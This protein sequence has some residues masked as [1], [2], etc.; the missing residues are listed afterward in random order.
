M[1]STGRGWVKNGDRW[2]VATVP[3]DGSLTVRRY[4]GGGTVRLPA[5][6]VAEHVELGYTTTAARAQGMTVDTAHVV[7]G[8]PT[9]SR[10]T[11]YA[12]MTRGRH[13]NHIYVATDYVNDPDTRH[14]PVERQTAHDVLTTILTRAGADLSGHETIRAA[15]HTAA[16]WAQLLAEYDTLAAAADRDHWTVLLDSALPSRDRQMVAESEAYGP[17]IVGLRRAEAFGIDMR[18]VLPRLVA[19]RGLATADDPAAVLHERLSRFMNSVDARPRS[20]RLVAGLHPIA[21]HVSDTDLKRA[22]DERAQ[23]L[24]NRARTLAAQACTEHADWTRRLGSAPSDRFRRTAYLRC[25]ETVAAYRDQWAITTPDPLGPVAGR[26]S[27]RAAD[28]T[29]AQHAAITAR[30]VADVG[31]EWSDLSGMTRPTEREGPS[32]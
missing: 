16:G 13:S 14:G 12:A 4:R 25:L 17:L 18:D 22:L 11:L 27:A 6:Y 28:R 8:G 20:D 1:L 29:L 21:I 5:D 9:I 31:N 24:Q 32:L 3:G 30:R 15:Q 23:L 19:D 10:E 2:T 26:S 7:I